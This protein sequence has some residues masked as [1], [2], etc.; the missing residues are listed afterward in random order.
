MPMIRVLDR[1]HVIA[2]GYPRIRVETAQDT[3]GLGNIRSLHWGRY[4]QQQRR[5]YYKGMKTTAYGQYVCDRCNEYGIDVY[6]TWWDP[7][8]PGTAPDGVCWEIFQAAIKAMPS[9]VRIKDLRFGYMIGFIFYPEQKAQIWQMLQTW[10]NDAVDRQRY[11][12]IQDQL[13]VERP[14]LMSWGVPK[15][16]PGAPASA[17]DSVASFERFITDVRNLYQQKTGK[18]PFIMMEAQHIADN[19]PFLA[20]YADALWLHACHIPTKTANPSTITT[21]QSTTVTRQNIQRQLNTIKTIKNHFTGRPVVYVPGS[22]PQFNRDLVPNNQHGRVEA[23]SKAQV[24]AMFQM[25]KEHAQVLYS[26]PMPPGGPYRRIRHK[27]VSFTSFDEVQEGTCV[28]PSG[29]QPSSGVYSRPVCEYGFD[30]LKVIRDVFAD[31]VVEIEGPGIDP[32]PV[33]RP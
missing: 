24:T 25:V 22:M 14:I 13:G 21:A 3:P 2:G 26:Q 18:P 32:E 29:I 9:N 12:W 31:E 5:W 27:W 8:A 6:T 30:F 16:N 17:A 4:D 10:S 23:A 7:H 19:K 11:A 28:M 33:D 1:Y 20:K 15:V